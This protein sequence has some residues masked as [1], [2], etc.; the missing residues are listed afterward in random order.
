METS[1]ASLAASS[2]RHF[3]P[4]FRRL[5]T[6]L[7]ECCDFSVLS[8]DSLVAPETRWVYSFNRDPNFLAGCRGPD[9]RLPL[10]K[11]TI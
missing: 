11:S 8:M 6:K 10:L 7:F 9:P 4:Q 1:E 5:K 3:L 2:H